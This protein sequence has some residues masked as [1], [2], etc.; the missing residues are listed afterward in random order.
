MASGNTELLC[1]LS[2]KLIDKIT[3]TKHSF[4]ATSVEDVLVSVSAFELATLIEYALVGN[5]IMK[6]HV[7][8][9]A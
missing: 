4:G 1:A 5:G 2:K 9:S 6:K 7:G 8:E 3:E